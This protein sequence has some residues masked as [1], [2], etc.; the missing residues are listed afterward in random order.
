MSP[1]DRV[2]DATSAISLAGIEQARELLRGVS[3]RTPVETSTSPG[4]VA[5]MPVF[6]KC[7]NLQRT[8]SFKFRG[9]FTRLSALSAEERGRGVVAASAGNHA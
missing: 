6:L 5:G 1:A 3:A 2:D 7:E 8:G 4:A 9:A